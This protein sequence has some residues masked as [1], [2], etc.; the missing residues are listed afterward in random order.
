MMGEGG[1]RG[2]CARGGTGLNTAGA[3][4]RQAPALRPATTNYLA[5]CYSTPDCSK[6]HVSPVPHDE[7]RVPSLFVR[8]H[9]KQL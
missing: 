5:G 4:W 1:V 7:A 3:P 6:S 2:R 9:I 8:G